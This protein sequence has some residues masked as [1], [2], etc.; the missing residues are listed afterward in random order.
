MIFYKRRAGVLMHISSIPSRYV[1]GD[2]GPEAFRFVDFLSDS[3]IRIWQVLPLG[4][5]SLEFANSPY[6]PLS[7]FAGN[8]IFISPEKLYES[9][10]INK[11]DLEHS[12]K[13]S[14][15]S[16]KTDYIT[17]Y[18]FKKDILKRAWENF[19]SNKNTA[20]FE[21]FC[22]NNGWWLEDYAL[23]NSLRDKSKKQWHQWEEEIKHRRELESLKKVL[24]EEIEFSKFEQ[25]VFFS[26]WNELKRYANS[27]GI[28]IM[29]DTPIYPSYDSCDVWC[30]TR[31]FKLDQN[32]VPKVVGGVPP[33][34]F[35]QTGQLWGNPVYDWDELEREKFDFW[36]KKLTFLFSIYDLVRLDHF[37]GFVAYWE[38]PY[39]EE[40]AVNGRWVKAPSEKFFSKV[41]EYFDRERIIVEDLGFITDD[42][43]YT[44]DKFGF[45]GMK[46]L[47]FAFYEKNSEYLPHNYTQ[48][49][50]CYTGTHDNPPAKLWFKQIDEHTTRNLFSYI[51]RNIPEDEI[52]WELVRLAF[53]SVSKYA[54][55]QM[56]DFIG[57]EDRMNTPSTTEGNWLWKIPHGFEYRELDERIRNLCEIYGRVD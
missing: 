17:A 13:F 10:L 29:G 14:S 56:Q 28:L 7:S 30:N 42:V 12:Y 18:R 20:D 50:V 40:T 24:K 57:S 47:E 15:K 54:I 36:M 34:F 19:G 48:N 55:V 22:Y 4:P 44:R 25:F 49:S 51:G 5:T 11:D 3:G 46:V 32:L 45:A 1:V 43:R 9:G 39:G 27:K 6:H 16:N 38:V 33:D 31:I 41:V 53:S 26:Q 52:N 35:S 37:R 8:Y 23:F 2:M 21:L